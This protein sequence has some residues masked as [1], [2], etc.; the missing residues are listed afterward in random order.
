MKKRIGIIIM[1]VL[2]LLLL[3]PTGALAAGSPEGGA[4]GL[5]SIDNQNKYAG[6]DK[7]FS[8]GYVP[9]Q[10]N[11][12]VRVVV[13]L[14]ASAPI[15]NNTITVTPG[16][17]EPAT[18][19][20][21]FG[22]YIKTVTLASQPVNDGTGSVPAYLIDITLPLAAG[23][24]KG[25]YPITLDVTYKAADG[26]DTQQT[27]T[28]YAT[29]DGKNPESQQAQ[30]G[31]RHQPKVIVSKYGT[32]PATVEAGKDFQ[33]SF[34]LTNT[35][36]SYAISNIK[37][38]MKSSSPDLAPVNDT[39]TLYYK[40]L[41]KG[42]NLDITVPMHVKEDATTEAHSITVTVEYEDSKATGYSASEDIPI[43]VSQPLRV[44]FDKPS[45]P[46]SMNAGD[47]APFTMQVMNKG[48]STVY[49]VT[50]VLEAPGL[51]PET[52]AFLGNME[53]G[54][55]KPAQITVFAGTKDM[56][57]SSDGNVQTGGADAEKYGMTAGTI[58]ITYEDEFGKQYSGKADIQTVINPPFI[59]AVAETTAPPK[60]SQWWI[61]VLIAAAVIAAIAGV[62][63]LVRRNRKRKVQGREEQ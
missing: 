34:T 37:V 23:R 27:F 46:Q 8:A 2:T 39:N 48:R 6:M 52:S 57:V 13:P 9:V 30:E 29:V 55:A 59:P 43:T 51:L 7:T 10:T 41:G 18:S 40:S 4:T 14:I 19:P 31:P 15:L 58:T 42:K 24:T 22:N 16:L 38:T 25:S 54:T 21:V 61:S 45:I 47:T 35:S 3:V 62:L 36:V 44:E 11:G 63:I 5:L 12:S 32:D 1:V 17:G 20:F 50:C 26:T 28:L 56:S 60:A 53:A 33:L 49:N